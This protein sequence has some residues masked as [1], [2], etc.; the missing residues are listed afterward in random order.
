[1]ILS[2]ILACVFSISKYFDFFSDTVLKFSIFSKPLNLVW[3]CFSYRGCSNYEWD[4]RW[5]EYPERARDFKHPYD[6]SV[7]TY[8]GH[9]VLRT[10]IR[11]YFS[12]EYR[13]TLYTLRAS[14]TFVSFA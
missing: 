11:C 13:S 7:A 10:L 3:L 12:P 14:C 1:M 6:Q 8:K 9:S 4:Y 5:M 2:W